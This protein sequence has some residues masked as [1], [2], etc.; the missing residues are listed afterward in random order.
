M[1]WLFYA[2]TVG[3]LGSVGLLLLRVVMGVAFIL[4]GWPKIQN[5]FAWMGPEAPTHGILQLTAAV[6]VFVGG[7]ALI[8]GLLTRLAALGIGAT[9]AVALQFHLGQGDPFVGGPGR[10]S[11]ELAAVYLAC[12]A[13]F[14]L[15]GPGHFSVDSFLF[16]RRP[17][18]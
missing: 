15:L 1:R 12:A 7:M 16:R 13:L 8:A 18:Q 11:Y 3:V 5:P 2:D 14:L 9:M 10:A 17:P 6:S 4:H